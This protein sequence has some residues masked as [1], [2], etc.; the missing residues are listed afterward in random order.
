ML[1]RVLSEHLRPYRRDLVLVVVLQTVQAIAALSLPTINARIIDHGII[2]K[3][4]HY[5]YRW[6][7]VMVGVAVIQITFTVTAV[8]FGGRAAM[9][10]GRDL[11]DRL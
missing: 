5:I 6:G 11:R 10:F 2:A 4:T 7:A 3:D 8:W 9:A 1:R